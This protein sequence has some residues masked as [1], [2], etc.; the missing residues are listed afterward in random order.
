MAVN[1]V[2]I[3]T[4]NGEE[5][6]I[7]LTSDTV[8]SEILAEGETA[9]DASGNVIRGTMPTTS[10]LYTNQTLTEA[11]KA[12]ARQN[13]GAVSVVD[14]PVKGVDYWTEADQESIVQQVLTVMG[15]HIVGV[16]DVNNNIVLTGKL[17]DGVYTLKYEDAEGNVTEIG[18]IDTRPG[19]TNMLL[20]AVDTDDTPYNGGQGW[21]TDTRLSSSGAESTSSAAGMEVTGFI[22][23]KRGDVIRFSGITMNKNSANV[24]RCYFIQYD[25]SKTMLKQWIVS[26]FNAAISSGYVL[27]D[28]DGNIIQINT[29]SF[30]EDASYP[31]MDNAAYFRI[32][33]DEINADS[34]I[35][36][37]QEIT[38]GNGDTDET[39]T[40]WIPIST[41]ENGNILNGVGYVEGYRINSS[42]ALT[43]AAGVSTTGY[44]P[45]KNGDILRSSAGIIGDNAGWTGIA[46]Y[47]ANKT[48]LASIKQEVLATSSKWVV[49]DDGS[50]YLDTTAAPTAAH[51]FSFIRF[52]S[53]HIADEGAVITVNEE[54]N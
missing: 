50:F 16:V 52:H 20:K 4:E 40:N 10:V 6:L 29:G 3:N 25:S 12:Q 48:W 13:I 7:D 44:I 1:K 41:D 37:N 39:Y 34:I 31:I 49:N 36:I 38:G 19:Y 33:A 21:K 17:T 8:K 15:M 24:S 2:V 18:T 28:S 14:V 46:L 42:G 27:A 54:I 32:S 51:T 5:T 45:C 53:Q 30:P 47:D 22:P 23:F 11:Q 35:T 26:A 43:E 9:H